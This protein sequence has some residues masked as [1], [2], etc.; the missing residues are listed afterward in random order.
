MKSFDNTQDKQSHI[1]NFAII[2]QLRVFD[3]TIFVRKI[4]IPREEL[5]QLYWN[6]RKSSLEIAQLFHCHS[7]T[8][9]NRIRELGIPKRTPSDARMRY[10]KHD[11]SDNSI[12]KAYLLGFRLGDL[13]VYQTN[14]RSNLIVVRCHTTQMAQVTLMKRLFSSYGHV[15]VSDGRHGYNVNCYVNTTF[16]FLLPK[17]TQVPQ[18]VELLKA[19]TWAFI[20]GYVDA[21]GYFGINQA[22]ARFKMDSYDVHILEWMMKIFWLSSIHAKFRRI[23]LQGQSQYRVGTFH[24][25]LWRLEINEA[26]SIS[27]FIALVGRYIRHEK[28]KADMMMCLYNVQGRQKEGTIV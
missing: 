4:T 23:A 10:E 25:D 27:R 8:I 24:K 7:M 21:E 18:D 22:K 11:F 9:R 13:S 5:H 16:R 6:E 2:A 12:D 1:R 3:Y 17:H 28:R 15:T 14:P 20:A 19:S 26:S